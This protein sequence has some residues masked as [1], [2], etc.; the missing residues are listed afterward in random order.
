M[1]YCKLSE[2][3]GNERLARPIMTN[4]YRELLAAGSV[5]KPE[6]ISRLSALGISEVFVQDEGL[7]LEQI[8]ILRD[9]VENLFKE[10]I[11]SVVELHVTNQSSEL[12]EL[13]ETA[14][15]I[16]TKILSDDKLVEQIFDLQERSADIYE[17]CVSVCTIAVLVAIKRKVS[18]DLIHDLGVA[19]L[20]HDI[21][22]R[23]L[24]FDCTNVII[25][26]LT[27]REQDDYHEHPRIAYNKLKEEKWISDRS[28]RII[29][30]HHERIDGSGFPSHLK[31]LD[32]ITQILQVCDTFDEMICGI[33]C[34][35]SRVYEAVEYMKYARD[36]LFDTDIVTALL[37][38][39]AVYPSG[40]VCFLNTGEM[41]VV[42]RQNKQFPERP[43]LRIVK[44]KFGVAVREEILCNLLEVHNVYID[45]VIM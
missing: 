9:D 15:D 32:E 23:Y 45:R 1:K 28:R 37:D 22:L 6:L 11:K 19:C 43:V 44:D 33:G 39:T 10:K 42:V 30:N 7:K 35:R 12:E 13:K 21:G 3:K 17:H 8:V 20:F 5:L 14:D 4:D 29:L 24:D 31:E 16:I 27:Y 41:C 36:V 25:D 26:E 34:K 2:L 38:F 40:T 18:R